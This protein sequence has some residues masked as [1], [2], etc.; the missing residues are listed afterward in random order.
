[1]T[2]FA[3]TLLDWYDKN[4]RD[5]PWR[6]ERDPYRVWLSEVMLQQTRAETVAGYYRAFLERFPTVESLA[7]ADMVDV[8]KQWEG[9]G[10]YS[11]A[12]NLHRA[13][14]IVVAAGGFPG[15]VKGLRA[16]PG[17]GEYTAG[18]IA[19]IAFDLP[20][21][22]IDGNQVRVLSRVFGIRAL[23]T[24]PATR[25]AL[26]DAAR[27]VIP[28]QRPGDFNQAMMGL[29]A[30]VCT[31]RPDCARCPVA[32]MCDARRA[33][34]ASALPLMPPKIEKRTE[35]R[36][37]ALVFRGEKVLV[38]RR[39]EEGLLAGLYEF[40][41]FAGARSGPEV[42]EALREIGVTARRLKPAGSARHVFT[43]LI[44]Q[45][46]GWTCEADKSDGGEFV[47]AAALRALPFPT[48]LRAFHARALEALGDA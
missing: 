48:A 1:L 31:P 19:S 39:P 4:A 42:L 37:V 24:A 35:Q 28:P 46:T 5:L 3:R 10:Y 13:A 38:R 6:L 18:A 44:W 7:R 27:S 45:M 14:G 43:H 9:L 15:D 2:Q 25:R 34:D 30:L 12:R 11:R 41:S 26:K 29:G 32:A 23:A 33:G 21:P 16:L 17:V 22:A 47:T 8:L 36:A 40:P 20:E